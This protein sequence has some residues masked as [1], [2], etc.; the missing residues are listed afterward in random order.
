MV[1]S[2][3]NLPVEK[4]IVDE[5][6]RLK[7]D[8][9][10]DGVLL[11]LKS[12][13]Q[14]YGVKVPLLVTEYD[15]GSYHLVDG[16]RRLQ[17]AIALEYKEIICILTDRENVSEIALSINLHRE[18]LSPIEVGNILMSIYTKNKLIDSSYKYFNLSKLVNKSKA[19]ISQHVGYIEKLSPIIQQ[20]IL[21]NKRVVD[22]NSLTRIY[23]LDE[24]N[25][26]IIYN[27][28]I[29]E[30]L[31]REDVQKLINELSSD[32]NPKSD[33]SQKIPTKTDYFTFNTKVVEFKM[34]SNSLSDT[35]MDMF[36]SD[37]S[38]LLEKYNLNLEV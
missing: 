34:L 14:Q 38:N 13:I 35:D 5:P 15:D 28:M 22:K 20:D 31:G 33:N 25:Q 19:Y 23:K 3:I 36:K 7:R 18:D 4:I 27:Q 29:S 8:I 1:S 6:N 2:V 17:V 30:N 26:E 21:D 37:L 32:T 9:A 16:Y 10:Q 12:N 24:K 11:E